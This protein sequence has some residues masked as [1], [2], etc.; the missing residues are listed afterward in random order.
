MEPRNKMGRPPK[1]PHERHTIQKNTMF[2]ELQY[3]A[4]SE[5]A[6]LLNTNHSG[7]LRLAAQVLI[8]RLDAFDLDELREMAK[9]T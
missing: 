5:T 4:I 7:M 9:T 2:T 3:A 1:E 6:E 8:E